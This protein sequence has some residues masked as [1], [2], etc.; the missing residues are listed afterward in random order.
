MVEA[1]AIG[2][3][4]GMKLALN[5]AAMLLAFLA[6]LAMLDAMLGWVGL[7]LGFRDPDGS[8]AWTL[9]RT[10]GYAFAPIAWSM[11]I[12]SGDCLRAGELLGLKTMANEFI[13]YQRLGQWLE[14]NSEVQLAPRSVK[15]LTYALS[16]FS[17]FSAIGIQI[18][19]IGHLA[20]SRQADLARLGLR[21]M[22]GGTLACCMTGCIAGLLG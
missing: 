1:A 15:I 8:P 21:A 12:E 10:L 19:G 11:G 3:S 17:N 4:D 18:G 16:G 9:S 5:V 2:A 20:P 14:P 22:L 13:A 7:L 6:L